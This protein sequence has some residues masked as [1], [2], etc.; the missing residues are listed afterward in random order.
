MAQ[1]TLL[2][3]NALQKMEFK[4]HRSTKCHLL[5]RAIL[6]T[7]HDRTVRLDMVWGKVRCAE[8]FKKLLRILILSHLIL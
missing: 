3:K 6:K 4:I 5:W 2:S 8:K 7:D 1:I